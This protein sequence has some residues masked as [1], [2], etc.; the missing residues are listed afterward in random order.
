MILS[1][2]RVGDIDEGTKSRIHASLYF[3][4]LSAT[5][6]KHIVRLNLKRIPSDLNV[7]VDGKKILALVSRIWSQGHRWSGRQLKNTC[8]MALALARHDSRSDP[9]MLKA[10]HFA[11]VAQMNA[12]FSQY[13]AEARGARDEDLT[14]QL[15]LRND[16]FDHS[17]KPIRLGTTFDWDDDSDGDQVEESDDS[18]D[19]E[20][21]EDERPVK[22]EKGKPSKSRRKR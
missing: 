16:N 19:T 9:V 11:A 20:D 8:T 2:T 21:S 5:G 17:T 13:L 4:P 18:I 3:P 15:G 22:K 10:S 1:T 6:A 14:L 12:S 7:Q